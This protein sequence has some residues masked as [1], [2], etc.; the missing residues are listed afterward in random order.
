M[1]GTHTRAFAPRKMLEVFDAIKAFFSALCAQ[2]HPHHYFRFY[3]LLLFAAAQAG[4]CIC[5]FARRYFHTPP[6][7]T[8]NPPPLF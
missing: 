1:R 3:P 2:R 7:L 4:F 6:H 8:F 5:A